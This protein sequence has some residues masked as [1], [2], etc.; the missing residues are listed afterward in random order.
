MGNIPILILNSNFR[1]R[2][3]SDQATPLDLPEAQASH[4]NLSLVLLSFISTSTVTFNTKHKNNTEET[5]SSGQLPEYGNS[6]VLFECLMVDV[7]DC[8]F[9]SL[10]KFYIDF[11][12]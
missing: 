3:K 11:V 6:S 4:V 1:R 10:T 5:L 9:Y 8:S 12:I 7:D 2:R